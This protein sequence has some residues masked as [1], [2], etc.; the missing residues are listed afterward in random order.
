[1]R[2]KSSVFMKILTL[3][4]PYRNSFLLSLLLAMAQ[5]V[6]ALLI[7]VI[8]GNTVDVIVGKDRVNFSKV[9]AYILQMVFVTAVGGLSQWTMSMLHNRI[10][11]RMGKDLRSRAM[12]KILVLP[13][14]FID[15][16]SH[17]EM[18]SRIV[19]D[20]EQF[21]EGALMGFGQFFTGVMTILLTLAFILRFNP[22]L[23]MIVILITPLSLVVSG[24]VAKRSFRFF[25]EQTITRGEMTGIANEM[26]EGMTTI[27]AFQKEERAI[28]EFAIANQNLGKA[29]LNAIFISAISNPATRFVNSLV[30]AGVGTAGA[31]FALSGSIT[32]GQLVSILSYATQ[33]TKPFN[34]ISGVISELQNSV[35]CASRIFDL[36]NEEEVVKDKPGSVSMETCEGEFKIQNI[37]FSYDKTKKFIDGLSVDVS[38]GKRIAIVGP[39][40]C[41]KTTLINLILRFYEMDA[42]NI[43]LD[44]KDITDIKREDY[45]ECFGMVLQDTWLMEGTIRENIAMGCPNAS[46]EDIIFAAKEAYAHHFI[47]RLPDGYDTVVKQNGGN[48]SAGQRQLLCIARVILKKPKILILDEATSSID[49]RTEIKLAE[50]FERLMQGRT[51][52]IVAHRLS[53]IKNADTIL[54]MKDGAVIESGNH[55]ELL[56]AG[57][58]YKKLYQSQFEG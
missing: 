19:S 32:V 30:Y 37:G 41:G 11:Y 18:V 6:S 35:A 7:P 53:T 8:I 46:M 12:D 3:L 17:G 55:N 34:E 47:R 33:Y 52:F 21:S 2:K 10:V 57:G 25:K 9:K 49:T 38:A 29:Y 31:Y 26:I 14:Q 1:M 43:L 5:V 13:I 48:L 36:L 56:E 16:K 22:V 58:F 28:S 15:K 39:T 54:V 27:K 44:N 50:G 45:V 42:G 23:A 51:C 20:I 24:F 40:G 4:K